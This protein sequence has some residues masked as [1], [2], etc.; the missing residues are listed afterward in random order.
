MG[1]CGREM[2][3]APGAA[4]AKASGSSMPGGLRRQQPRGVPSRVGP[5]DHGKESGSYSK[6]IGGF[7]EKK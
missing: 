2:Y 4:S 1:I 3:R 6:H 7:G 5:V